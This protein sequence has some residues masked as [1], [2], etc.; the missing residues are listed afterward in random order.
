LSSLLLLTTFPFWFLFVRGHLRSV[1]HTL[2]V[3]L[4]FRTWVGYAENDQ[5]ELSSLPHLKKGILHPA[6]HLSPDTLSPERVREVNV[7]YAKDYKVL[8]DLQI[9]TRN[10]RN[11]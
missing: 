10:F 11:I 3:L 2:L 1:W 9:L 7:V 6:S 4:G 5:L 8:Q